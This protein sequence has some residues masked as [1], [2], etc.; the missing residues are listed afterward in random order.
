HRERER[1]GSGESG[2]AGTKCLMRE[3][4]KRYACG[5]AEVSRHTAWSASHSPEPGFA[6]PRPTMEHVPHRLWHL[7]VPVAICTVVSA[8]GGH[9]ATSSLPR[10]ERLYSSAD[11]YA[12]L[13][14]LPGGGLLIGDRLSGV[15]RRF[16]ADGR[17]AS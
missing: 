6:I 4:R 17:P 8:C 5:G 14:P 3:A 10:R 15:V 9:G 7:L 13:V 2:D 16:G 12:A 11:V 1:D